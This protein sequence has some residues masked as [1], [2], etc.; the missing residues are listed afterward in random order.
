[1]KL[2]YV[3]EPLGNASLEQVLELL[4]ATGYSYVELS[5]APDAP[6]FDAAAASKRERAQLRKLLDKSGILGFSLSYYTGALQKPGLTDA[7]QLH[8]RKVIDAAAELEAE[9]VCMLAGFADDERSHFEIISGELPEMLLPIID[10]AADRDVRIAFENYFRGVLRGADSIS[11]FFETFPSE[12]VG[13]CY[14]PSH[15]LVQQ[16]NHI[17]PLYAFAGRLFQVHAKDFLESPAMRENSGIFGNEYWRYTLPGRGQIHWGQFIAHLEAI[18]Y[19]GALCVEDEDEATEPAE[20][21]IL[22]AN[23]LEQYLPL[24]GM[25]EE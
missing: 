20:S 13:L 4:T 18:G 16:C 11:L 23:Y 21:V 9:H 2:G 14:D 8:A 17:S 22:A 3:V 6:Y 15:M 10:Y 7:V 1:M 24:P 12:H 5:A 25:E 19:I